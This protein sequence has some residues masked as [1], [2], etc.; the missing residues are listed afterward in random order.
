[1]GIVATLAAEEDLPRR[2]ERSV[3]LDEL[4]NLRELRADAGIGK[5]DAQTGATV[6][7]GIHRLS[8]FDRAIEGILRRLDQGHA[9]RQ[10][11]HLLQRGRPRIRGGRYQPE[12]A[13]AGDRRL[14]VLAYQLQRVA[15]DTDRRRDQ[16][17]VQE[18]DLVG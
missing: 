16:T 15:A 11:E 17:A 12:V 9:A 1:M 4:G 18:T 13:G 7:R 3:H 10:T 8:Y 6:H 14:R 2:A 5:H